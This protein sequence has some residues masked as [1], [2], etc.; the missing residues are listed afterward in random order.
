MF[1]ILTAMVWPCI[2]CGTVFVCPQSTY[3]YLDNDMI[4]WIFLVVHSHAFCM[5]HWPIRHLDLSYICGQYHVHL[6]DNWPSCLLLYFF[7]CFCFVFFAAKTCW[8]DSTRS[9]QLTTSTILGFQ[10]KLHRHV[11][12]IR[13]VSPLF[14][15]QPCFLF[16]SY[17]VVYEICK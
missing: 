15:N 6:V 3:L 12:F 17:S 5:W 13:R 10:F 1:S 11:V 9:K 8:R 14:S 2:V 4:F 7:D 16:I